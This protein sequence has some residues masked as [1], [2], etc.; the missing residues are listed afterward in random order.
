MKTNSLNLIPALLLLGLIVAPLSQAAPAAEMTAFQLIKEGNRYVGEDVKDKVVQIRS[1]KSI[2]GLAPNIWYIVYYNP[3]ATFL[4]TEVKFAAGKKVS[5]KNPPRLLE[6]VTGAH[7]PLDREKLKVD[8]DK[9]VAIASKEPILEKLTLKA[10]ALKLERMAP[11]SEQPVW[12][13]RL[14]AAKLKNPN[15]SADIGQIFV[16]ADDGKVVQTDV[17]ANRID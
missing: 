3:D 2:G 16:A 11:D 4:S 12:K 6:P 1:E 7:K 15:D 14:W 5:V 9:A 10:V 8:S 17:H 13:V